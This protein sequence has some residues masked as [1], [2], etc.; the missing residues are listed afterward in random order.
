MATAKITFYKCIQDSQD[1]GSDDDCMVSRV[2]FTFEI[3]DKKYDLYADIKQTAG[4]HIEEYP[5][6]VMRPEGYQGPF[7]YQCFRDAAEKYY[8]SLVGSSGG[9]I[10]IQGG[11]NIRMRDNTFKQIVAVECDV[12][13]LTWAW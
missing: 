5:V 9:G 2:F 7:P 11:S 3:G 13:G 1:Y 4:S 8:R 12:S 10:N 6:E